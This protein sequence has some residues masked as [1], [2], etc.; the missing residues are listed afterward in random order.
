[1]KIS[2]TPLNRMLGAATFAT[3]W[4]LAFPLSSQAK[5]HKDKHNNNDNYNYNNGQAYSWQ[6]VTGFIQGLGNNIVNRGQRVIEP[7]SG[8]QY[9]QQSRERY[10]QQQNNSMEAAIQMALN[11]NGYYYGPI[12]GNLG[13]MSRQA[14]ARYQADRGLRVTGSPNSNLLRS[15]GL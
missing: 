12:D 7:N 5:D 8:Y 4:L 11:R 2:S 9:G 13:P 6:S 3:I 1:M 14:I 15:L 10:Y